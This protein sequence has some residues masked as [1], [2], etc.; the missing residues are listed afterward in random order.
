VD[1]EER[2]PEAEGLAAEE[3][4]P[5]AGLDALV[6]HA[7]AVHA[8]EVLD[9]DALAEVQPRVL[10]RDGRVVDAQ[11]AA[12]GPAQHDG[13][14]RGQRVAREG[15]GA[16]DDELERARGAGHGC[17]EGHSPKSARTLS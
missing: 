4:H 5:V 15:G 12:V 10:A 16:D 13:A 11:V 17:G 3:R 7:G 14:A 8:A 2:A 9:L 1:D 6:A